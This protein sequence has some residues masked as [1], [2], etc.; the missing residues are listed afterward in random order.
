MNDA[1]RISR[2]AHLAAAVLFLAVG[3]AGADMIFST[4]GSSGDSYDRDSG[5]GIGH[6]QIGDFA[7]AARFTVT[8][9]Q[10]YSLSLIEL[11]AFLNSGYNQLDVALMSDAGNKPGTILESFSF[12]GQMGTQPLSLNQKNP[13]L[14]GT[15]ASDPHPLLVAG[16]SY[17]LAASVPDGTSAAWSWAEPTVSGGSASMTNVDPSWTV[18]HSALPAF[19]ISGE[20]YT[21]PGAPPWGGPAGHAWPVLGRLPDATLNGVMKRRRLYA[22]DS[23]RCPSRAGLGSAGVEGRRGRGAPATV[24][25]A[26]RQH[27]GFD[28]NAPGDREGA[29]VCADRSRDA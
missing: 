14:V 12:V 10:S 27:A 15:S 13:V 11:A 6:S 29:R 3:R 25:I 2:I 24:G 4:F 23:T 1:R 16:T 21:A 5:W 17:W 19:R 8:G 18:I 22:I 26:R 7:R 20:P 28:P 9:P